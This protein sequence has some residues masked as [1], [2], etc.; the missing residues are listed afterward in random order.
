MPTR[1]ATVCSVRFRVVKQMAISR[2][3]SATSAL[4]KQHAVDRGL[5]TD[6]GVLVSRS[7]C[8][9]LHFYDLW[10]LSVQVEPLFP[11]TWFGRDLDSCG[12]LFAPGTA[13]ERAWDAGHASGK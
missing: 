11:R 10:P 4:G 9:R 13:P 5:F 12:G 8:E 3:E 2:Q 7:S 6:V 1:R